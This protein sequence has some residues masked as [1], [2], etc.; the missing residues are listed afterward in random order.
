MELPFTTPGRVARL[1]TTTQLPIRIN[2]AEA[3]ALAEEEF[4]R[5]ADLA[6]TLKDDDWVIPPTALAGTS[7]RSPCTSSVRRMLRRR[8][9]SSRI[10]SRGCLRLNRQMDHDHWVDGLNEVQIRERA[11]LS[12][13]EL[14]AALGAIGPRAVAG[15]WGTRRPCG[16]CPFRSA[17]RSAG[18]P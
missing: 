10:S 16:A 18:R 15:R 17:A 13:A 7:V 4:R 11:H 12:A 14:V 2:R 6:A 9:G 8:W 5:F 1:L 3:R